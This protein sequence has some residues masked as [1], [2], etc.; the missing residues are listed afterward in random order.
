MKHFLCSHILVFLLWSPFLWAQSP[1]GAVAGE[2]RDSSGAVVP[3]VVLEVRHQGN[4]RVYSAFTNRDG[5]YEFLRLPP[6]DYE[7]SASFQGFNTVRHEEVSLNAGQAITL[8]LTLQVQDAQQSITVVG[9][10]APLDVS[11]PHL[12]YIVNEISFS[13]LPINGRSLDSLALLA[14]GMIP[15]RAKE[16]RSL[17]GLTQEI[18]GNGARGTEYQLDGTDIQHPILKS[19]PGGVSGLFLGM[20][21]VQEFEILNDAYPAYLGGSGGAT[22]NVISRRGTRDFHGSA[23]WF[24]RDSALDAR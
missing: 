21:S 17:T 15:L 4:G 6:G 22:V 20:D 3:D 2:V 11:S 9:E 10:A 12:S 5:R 24:Y 18:S 16:T 8:D 7:L 14:P 1:V 19:T 23:F 13:S